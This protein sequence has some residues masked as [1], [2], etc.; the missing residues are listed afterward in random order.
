MIYAVGERAGAASI[1]VIVA[2]RNN[3]L[4]YGIERMTQ[5]LDIVAGVRSAAGHPSTADLVV[6][7]ARD[8]VVVTLSEIDTPGSY[9]LRQ[10]AD[11][12]VKILLLLDDAEFVELGR[13]SSVRLSGFLTTGELSPRSLS[14]A[15]VR[16]D[17]GQL[18]ISSDL[19]SK[20]MDLAKDNSVEIP[21][22]APRITPR[23]QEA[24]AL[25]V[26]GLSNKQIA[27]RLRIS[28][29]GAKRLVANILAKMDCSN[30]TLAVARAL[31]DGLYELPARTVSE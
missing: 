16:I 6:D 1:N 18:S 26:D 28:E 20:L 2:I 29:H 31:R 8:I 17:E 21:R 10:W 15:L 22:P 9:V 23:E 24:L 30:R 7:P 5:A 11:R 12:G 27:R 3:L 4:R 13:V 14:D 25:L 19:L